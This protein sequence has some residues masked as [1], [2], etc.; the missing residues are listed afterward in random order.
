M[1][2]VPAAVVNGT[3]AANMPAAVVNGAVA[4]NMPAAVVATPVPAA[5]S[6]TG[7]CDRHGT[8]QQQPCGE[9][10]KQRPR[11]MTDTTRSE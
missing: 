3:V 9:T 10:P 6:P 5:V 8:D 11:S 2:V 7:P 1:A 4:A